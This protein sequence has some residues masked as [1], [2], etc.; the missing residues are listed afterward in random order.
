MRFV[1]KTMH[2]YIDYPVG[3]LLIAAPFILGIGASNP[4]AMWLS[5]VTGVAALILTFLTD[6]ET[7]VVKVL[8]YSFHLMVD[9]AVGVAFVAAPFILG[10]KGL[11][12]AYYTVLGL[13][14][15]A[16]VGLHK[17][18]ATPVPA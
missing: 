1:T 15:L 3:L 16:V 10:F 6:H 2:A 7:G 8:P 17:P 12:M 18:D 14:V 13:T 9:F 11:D 4:I 5:V